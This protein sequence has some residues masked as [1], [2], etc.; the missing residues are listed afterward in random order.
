M[1]IGAAPRGNGDRRSK[2]NTP[3][4][5][6]RQTMGYGWFMVNHTQ[7]PYPHLVLNPF[8]RHK[9]RCSGHLGND[10]GV[11]FDRENRSVPAI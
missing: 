1:V 5:K 3:P 6:K 8:D 10:G 11:G 2:A 7:L 9:E 4:E